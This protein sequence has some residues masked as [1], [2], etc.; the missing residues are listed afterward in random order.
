[1]D[2]DNDPTPDLAIEA[3]VISKTTLD[4]YLAL[5]VPEAWLYDNGRLTIQ[6]LQDGEYQ[7]SKVSLIFPE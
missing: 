1:M 7:E 5:Q 4:A 3:D 6:L 2:M